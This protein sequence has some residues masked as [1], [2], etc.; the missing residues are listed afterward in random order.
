VP[1]LDGVVR[2]VP[3]VTAAPAPYAA[4]FVFNWLSS[5]GT[6][7]AVAA[8]LAARATGLGVR[9]FGR[10][11]ARTARRLVLPELTI[12]AVLGLAYVMNYCGATATLGLALART[13]RLFPFF[14]TFLGWLGVFLTGSDTSANALFGNLQI[15]SARALGINPVLM[16]AVNSTGGVLGKMISVQS[17]AVAAA[18]T[19]MAQGSEGRLFLFT[20]AHSIA[21]TAA[22]G[23]LALLFAYVFPG[24][25]P[26]G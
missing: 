16:A 6:A 2:R 5:A 26:L 15:I 19:G 21:L 12:A 25:I 11:A 24:A 1:G 9:S 10:V 17:I 3:P 23:V 14:G 22:M 8:L 18:A 7:C 13:G 20:L 4:V